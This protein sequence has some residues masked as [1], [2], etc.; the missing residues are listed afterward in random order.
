LTSS[1]RAVLPD[2]LSAGSPF[3]DNPSR[4]ARIRLDEALVERGLAPTRARARDAILRGCVMLNGQPARKAGQRVAVD[5]RIRVQDD[6]LAFVARSALKLLAGLEHFT[7]DVTGLSALDVGASTGGFTQTLLQRGARRVIALDVGHDQL[8]PSLRNDPRVTVLEG[9]N[10]RTLTAEDLPY[11]PSFVTIDVSF[12]AQRLIL[13]ALDKVVAPKT[14][15]LT[16]VKPQFEIGPEAVGKD[17]VVTEPTLHAQAVGDVARELARLGWQT[18]EALQSPITGGK[19]NQEF[20]LNA[21]KD[22]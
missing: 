9:I 13:P 19:G 16:L 21:W 18:G 15:M 14:V 2:D 1:D 4:Q 5:A 17:G 3:P 7:I 8:H 20:L 22:N 11:R 12:I 10:A 6:A